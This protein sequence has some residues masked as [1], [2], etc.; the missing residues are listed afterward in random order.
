LVV[1]KSP[2]ESPTSLEN[3]GSLCPCPSYIIL[4]FLVVPPSFC[5]DSLHMIV[6][7]FLLKNKS[8]EGISLGSIGLRSS[9]LITYEQG[10]S[11][12][13][14]RGV[15]DGIGVISAVDSP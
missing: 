4:F 2:N 14:S 11:K 5:L 6:F 9:M 7:L 12:H 8:D 1:A 15:K 3:S 10:R 13:V